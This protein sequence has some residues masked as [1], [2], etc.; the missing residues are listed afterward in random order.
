MLKQTFTYENFDGQQVTEDLYFNLTKVELSENF[1]LKDRVEEVQKMLNGPARDLKPEETFKVLEV[2]KDFMKI[3]YGVRSEDGR[4]FVKNDQVWEEFSQSAAY[5]AFLFSLFETPERAYS[6]IV[7]V[8]PRDLAE[9]AAKLMAAQQAADNLG[10]VVDNS[11]Q[12]EKLKKI[13]NAGVVPSQTATD[14]VT[15]D[16]SDLGEVSVTSLKDMNA[17]VDDDPK[18]WSRERLLAEFKKKNQ[19]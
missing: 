10:K 8:M 11:E 5:D 2:V 15:F 7:G 13:E 3:A 9:G 16:T 17:K 18:N 4:R 12:V 6:F 14:E 19:S 1:W